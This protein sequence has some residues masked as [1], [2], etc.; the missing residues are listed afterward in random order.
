MDAL[1]MGGWMDALSSG[2]CMDA[3]SKVRVVGLMH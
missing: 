3:L 1:S 2:G